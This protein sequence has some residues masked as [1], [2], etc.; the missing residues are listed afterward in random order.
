[1]F[2]KM[3]PVVAIVAIAIMVIAMPAFAAVTLVNSADLSSGMDDLWDQAENASEQIYASDGSLIVEAMGSAKVTW[4]GTWGA[5]YAGQDGFAVFQFAAKL[6]GGDGGNVAYVETWRGNEA[7]T[8]QWL[9]SNT[10]VQAKDGLNISTALTNDWQT[11]S[12]VLKTGAYNDRWYYAGSTLL[13]HV[14]NA[15]YNNQSIAGFTVRNINR[16][17]STYAQLSNFGLGYGDPSA[18]PEPSSL[19]ALGGLGLTALGMIKRRRA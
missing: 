12:V 8:S 18:V 4:W 14:N 19:L 6:G 1:M 3:I 15:S 2:K 7:I 13:G 9:V 11:F 17:D 10:A 16:D 5:Q